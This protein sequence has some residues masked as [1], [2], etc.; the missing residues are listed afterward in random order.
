MCEGHCRCCCCKRPDETGD[1]IGG[2]LVRLLTGL[3]L[4]AYVAYWLGLMVGGWLSAAVSFVTE[5]QTEILC[6]RLGAILVD[7]CLVTTRVAG[8][9]AKLALRQ[10]PAA[11]RVD[12]SVSR[13]ALA[14]T[15]DGPTIYQQPRAQRSADTQGC[16]ALRSGRAVDRRK[17]GGV[18]EISIARVEDVTEALWGCGC[19]RRRFWELNKA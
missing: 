10:R 6:V 12:A 14:R 7:L 11:P 4:T 17:Q 16:G 18:H 15:R 3:G 9:I 2:L 5:Y 13:A 1:G 19:L 8:H